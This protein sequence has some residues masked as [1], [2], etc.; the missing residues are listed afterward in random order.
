MVGQ[1]NSSPKEGHQIA[2]SKAE[3]KNNGRKDGEKRSTHHV[4]AQFALGFAQLVHHH[5]V[6]FKRFNEHAVLNGFLQNALYFAVRIA[7]FARQSSHL[8]HVSTTSQHEYRQYGYD[9]HSQNVV[10]GKEIA[11]RAHKHGKHRER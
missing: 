5:V 1:P 8:A 4:L 11:E 3:V 6:A 2:K 7:Y 9:N 10:H